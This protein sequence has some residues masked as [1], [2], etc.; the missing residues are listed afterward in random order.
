MEKLNLS[1][2]QS[3][4]NLVWRSLHA[5]EK[6]LLDVVDTYGDDSDEGADALND[7]V[8]LRLYKDELQE[9]AKQVFS[10]ENAFILEDV[11]IDVAQL[12]V[13]KD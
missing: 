1:L 8:V 6:E 9:Q 3:T 5:R 13:V 11:A 7:L 2:D 4:F 12:Y 10:D